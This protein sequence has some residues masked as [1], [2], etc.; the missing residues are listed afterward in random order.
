MKKSLLLFTLILLISCNPPNSGS[1]VSGNPI[2][3][4]P[5][6]VHNPPYEEFADADKP[7]HETL[8]YDDN[9]TDQSYKLMIPWNYDKSHN[10]DR[11]YPLVVSFSGTP[12]IVGDDDEMKGYPCFFLETGRSSWCQDLVAQLVEDY[13]IDTN[14]IYLTGFSAGGSGS[15][16]FA[17][18][19]ESRHNLVVAGIVRCAGGSNTALSD[20]IAGKTSVWYHVGLADGYDF[21]YGS[22]QENYS[23][24][25][26]D[27]LRK[28]NIAYDFVK[29]LTSSSGAIE[30]VQTETIS[31]YPR[32]TTTLNL[33][34]VEIFKRSHYE[35]MGHSPSPVYGDSKV[36][37]WLFN[38]NLL[39]RE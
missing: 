14:R 31:G 29:N 20:A 6:F 19:L 4:N 26:D 36:L 30:T 22:D 21:G 12:F 39:N 34:G 5:A 23:P 8:T 24:D 17:S 10:A 13:R 32:T 37:E 1:P 18:D 11:D 27:P 38:Q 35:G 2:S 7:V 15:Y 9:G 28:S 33:A 3:G 25:P 16:P